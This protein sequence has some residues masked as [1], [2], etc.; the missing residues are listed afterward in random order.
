MKLLQTLTTAL[1]LSGLA[2]S[3]SSA[4]SEV[5]CAWSELTIGITIDKDLNQ[6]RI[7]SGDTAGPADE[8]HPYREIDS[9]SWGH[10]QK[11]TQYYVSIESGNFRFEYAFKD[12]IAAGHLSSKRTD[13]KSGQ[14]RI[15][16]SWCIAPEDTP[17]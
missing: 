6:I 13:T 12:N 15:Q 11:G 2:I 16:H 5:Y 10:P 3:T 1:L 7:R 4:A 14:F 8:W 17:S 9:L